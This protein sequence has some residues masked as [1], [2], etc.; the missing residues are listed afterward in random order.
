MHFLYFRYTCR[1]FVLETEDDVKSMLKLHATKA[2]EVM[3]TTFTLTH[4][5]QS[6][7]KSVIRACHIWENLREINRLNNSL[8]ITYDL[9]TCQLLWKSGIPCFLDRFLPQPSNLPGIYL[10]F[11]VL[12]G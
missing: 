3:L 6:D 12:I 10:L 9:H 5:G 11:P 4:H 1:V 7:D 2:G 8:L